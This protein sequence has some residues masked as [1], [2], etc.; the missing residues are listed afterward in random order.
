MTPVRPARFKKVDDRVDPVVTLSGQT[1]T[2]VLEATRLT[3]GIKVCPPQLVQWSPYMRPL[4][5]FSADHFALR[6]IGTNW[7]FHK[8]GMGS[9]YL[10]GRLQEV[11]ESA[12]LYKAFRLSEQDGASDWVKDLELESAKV[13]QQP[14]QLIK[15]P[16]KI[17][18]LYGSLRER[19]YS[20]L[21]AYEF[22]R[23][24]DLLGTAD[25]A[26]REILEAP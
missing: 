22:A 8:F 24:L 16:P 25:R 11:S 1:S 14:G 19:S 23:I 7:K 3:Q 9:H 18:V 15:T 10:L 4:P 13:F 5:D 21:L 26:V 17:L 2:A 12:S 6:K 20:R